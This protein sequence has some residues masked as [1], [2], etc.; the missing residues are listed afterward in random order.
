VQESFASSDTLRRAADASMSAYAERLAE[1][2][3]AAVTSYRVEDS[4]DALSLA[5][6]VQA[7][8]QG[9]FVLAK[10]KADPA[11]A[12]DSAAHLKRYIQML[13]DRGEEK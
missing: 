11:I 3:A 2:V 10:A 4:V 12:R 1:D 6:H 8:L 5:Y 7:V 13:F 9:A